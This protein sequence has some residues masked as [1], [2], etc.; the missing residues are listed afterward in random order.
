MKINRVL[1]VDDKEENLYLLQSLLQGHSYEIVTAAH[2]AEALVKARQNPPD[3]IISD[4]LMP[5]MDGY[6]LLRNWK[7]DERLKTIPFVVYTATYIDERDE[8]LARD[9]GADDF[10]LKPTEPEPFIARINEAIAKAKHTDWPAVRTP[11]AENAV[12]VKEF[13]E[14]QVR[15]LE[16]KTLQ[17][18]ESNRALQQEI[19]ERK[20][21]EEALL[22]SE[23]HLRSVVQTAGDAIA[24]MD[25]QGKVRFW[26]GAAESMFGHLSAEM[27]GQPLIGV[28]PERF[29]GGF[30]HK[31]KQSIVTGQ[32]ILGQHPVEAIGLRRNGGEFPV[33]ITI[34]SW[35]E[36][37]GTFS[38]AIIRDITER[39]HAEEEIRKRVR[40][41]EGM[42][43]ISTILRTASILEKMLPSLLKETLAIVES[44]TGAI[45]LFDP[46][47]GTL[48]RAAA[49]GWLAAMEN[50]VSKPG[51]GFPGG[52]F[53]ANQVHV[54]DEF[55]HDPSFHALPSD[56]IPA[57]WGGAC[58][59]IQSEK[60][61]IGI[62][63][64]ALQ[65]PRKISPEEVSLLVTLSEIAGTAIQRTRLIEQTI[66]QLERLNT[67]HAIDTAINA[68]MDI[69]VT[70][71]YF[72]DQVMNQ[73]R[74]DAA[75]VLLCEPRLLILEYFAGRG[76][77]GNGITA[78]RMRVGEGHAGRAALERQLIHVA[79]MT[80]DPVAQPE[81]VA[82]EGFVSHTAVPL[83]AKGQV[84]GVL[85][86]FHRSPFTPEEDW[87][88][89]LNTLAGQAA[90]AINNA[91]L[92]SDLESANVNLARAND[93]TLEGWSRAMDLRDKETEGHSQ[94]VTETTLILAQRMGLGDEQL[95]HIR[96]GALLH[97]LGKLGVPDSILNKP[98]SLTEEE[99]ANMH[100]HPVLAYELLLPI[101]FLRP[102]LDIP[103]CHHERWDGSG[104]PRGLKG[105]QIPLS[106]RIFAVGDVIDALTSDRPYRKAWSRDAAVDYIREQSGKEF[107]PQ[108]VEAFLRKER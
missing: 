37:K 28:L 69:R 23:G 93:A 2:G 94:R 27:I 79:D 80:H 32:L 33:E 99:M 89:F 84:I 107:D 30:Q 88:E 65:L 17:L 16:E 87:L 74:V 75:A 19:I 38:T 43:R 26:N 46:T 58:F 72:L 98:G 5:M 10:I 61:I 68:N 66:N 48:R 60:E 22:Q 51:E 45:W 20:R 82:G 21:A 8:R 91:A 57:G 62:G 15:K 18:E 56:S 31:P 3:L 85:E 77:R 86:L 35:K 100:R 44:D 63:C 11:I 70:L 92:F 13:N 41:L 71:G 76:F 42:N 39:K 102:A 49:L 101:E 6:T 97:D 9:L 105:E 29:R 1:I 64:I 52:V 36:K 24:T 7:A 104:Y 47:T 34:S 95:V 103:Y 40:E 53:T 14:V 106:A 67:L 81:R 25:S 108:V 83:I 73:L 59:P 4:L 54:S 50:T 96:R 55:A 90:I 12:L 78:T